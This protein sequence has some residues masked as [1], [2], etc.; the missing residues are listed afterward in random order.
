MARTQTR[1]SATSKAKTKKAP[2]SARPAKTR[3]KATSKTSSKPTTQT[4][5]K[6]D[7]TE[8]F[9][10]K[11]K[12]VIPFAFALDELEEVGPETRLMFGTTAV[13]VGDKIVLALRDKDDFDSGVW[14]A[15]EKQHHES[16]LEEFPSMRSITLFGSDTSSWQVLPKSAADFESSV[17]RACE[18]IR[19]GDERIGTIPQRKRRKSQ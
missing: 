15:T 13:Y 8:L 4:R 5:S 12:R 2:A 1:S 7:S 9:V 10:E 6:R 3:S 18:L 14:L 16:L 19:R 11:K 17:L